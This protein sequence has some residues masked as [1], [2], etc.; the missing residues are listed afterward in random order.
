MLIP[1]LNVKLG[2]YRCLGFLARLY[3]SSG[4]ASAIPGLGVAVAQM[5]KFLAGLHKV[6][7]AIVVTSVVRVYRYVYF[8]IKLKR[9]MFVDIGLKSY[10]VPSQPT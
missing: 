2:I 5:L 8:R 1:L 3:E 10:A 4:R 6:H 9:C 7:G